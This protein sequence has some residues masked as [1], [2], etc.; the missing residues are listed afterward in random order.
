MNRMFMFAL[1]TMLCL[2]CQFAFAADSITTTLQKQYA[3]VSTMRS[4]FVQT[5]SHKESGAIEKR[6]GVLYFQKPMLV[7][8]E[9]TEPEKELLLV[10]DK[11]IW[12]EFADETLVYRYSLSLVA[13]SR[14]IVRVITGQSQIDQDFSVVEEGTENGLAKLRLYPNEPTQSMIEALLWVDTIGLIKK[15]RIY[16][17]Y[18]NTNEIAFSAHTLGVSLP[19][20][21]FFYSPPKGFTVEDRRDSATGAKNPLL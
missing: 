19:E 2:A 20:S 10:N 12:N 9:T 5:L 21:T 15:L 14:S 4:E 13:D 7:R 3:N 16:D 1:A 17:F 18:G 11:D 6:K 8:W